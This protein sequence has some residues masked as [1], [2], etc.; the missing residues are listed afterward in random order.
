MSYTPPLER[1]RFVIEQVLDAPAS[2][3]AMPDFAE[4]STASVT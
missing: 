2:W 3:R 4:A 1:M